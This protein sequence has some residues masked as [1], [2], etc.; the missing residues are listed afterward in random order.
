MS[1]RELISPSFTLSGL[2]RANHRPE[3]PK[4]PRRRNAPKTPLGM[5]LVRGL[6]VRTYAQTNGFFN[7]FFAI[8]ER[9]HTPAIVTLSLWMA[10]QGGESRE[11]EG[12]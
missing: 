11:E 1:I 9:N 3:R 4:T 2:P 7:A 10:E 12:S 5:S 8:A 6:A